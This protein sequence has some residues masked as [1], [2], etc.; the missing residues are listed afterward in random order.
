M[1]TCLKAFVSALGFVLSSTSLFA[2]ESYTIVDTGQT[3]CYGDRG[4]IVPPGPGEPFEGQD[5]QYQGPQPAYQ[6]NGDGTVS[7]LNTGLMW[8]QDRGEKVGWN[9]AVAGAPACR[10]GG[11]DDWRMPTIKEL[12]SLINFNGGFDH[13]AG[14]ARSRPYLDT[15]YFRF[16]YGDESKG[17][18][19]IDCQD[20]SA[21][22]YLGTTMNGNATVFGVN[23]AD[24]R[25][26]G[27]PKAPRGPGGREEKRLYVRYV[28]G[29]PAYGRNEFHVNGDGTI[30]DRATGLSWQKADSGK[31]LDWEQALAYAESLTLAG[32]DDWRLPNA[33]ELQSIVDYTRAPDAAEKAARGPALDRV[34]QITNPESYFWTG[35]THLEGPPD[36]LGDQAVYICFGRSMGYMRLPGAPMRQRINV[37]GAGAQRSDPKSGDPKRYPQGRGPQGDDV[38]IYHYVRCVRGG[39]VVRGE[40]AASTLPAAAKRET[41]RKTGR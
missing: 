15:S 7:D 40:A 16:A 39:E 27:Y 10:A 31:P 13:R 14:V 24:G 19:P 20:W 33:K 35:T 22:E 21:T 8:V 17:E 18:R 38:R 23:F 2:A 32:H 1:S 34:F 28:R 9:A 30:S 11:Y 36:S 26:K 6:D 41:T 5:A 12:Y 29:N 4:E 37:H 25:I 3:R